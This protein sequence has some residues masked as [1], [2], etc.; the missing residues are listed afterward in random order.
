M[1]VIT[2]LAPLANV[3]AN[4]LHV[5]SHFGCIGRSKKP[6]QERMQLHNQMTLVLGPR[7]GFCVFGGNTMCDTHKFLRPP[8]IPHPPRV[9]IVNS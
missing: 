4:L 3:K 8:P 1:C 7:P 5:A 9:V 2:H 6:N